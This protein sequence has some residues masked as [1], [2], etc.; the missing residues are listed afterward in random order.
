MSMSMSMSDLRSGTYEGPAVTINVAIN[1]VAETAPIG[2]G[3][4][5][6]SE[7]SS[8]PIRHECGCCEVCT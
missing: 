8:E 4:M 2:A 1:I 6:I 5:T 7:P 3:T